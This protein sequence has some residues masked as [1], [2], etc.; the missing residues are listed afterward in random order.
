MA[1]FGVEWQ[2]MNLEQ[3]RTGLG[4][5][6]G[7]GEPPETVVPMAVRFAWWAAL[8]SCTTI[9]AGAIAVINY[10]RH[11]AGNPANA[12]VVGEVLL[13]LVPLVLWPVLWASYGFIIL[14]R[15]NRGSAGGR[16]LSLIRS[17]LAL[18]LIAIH[19]LMVS[20]AGIFLWPNLDL[21]M[22]SLFAYIVTEILFVV[23]SII[24]LRIK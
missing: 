15:L 4:P 13:V 1:G 2:P 14:R 20:W 19:I 24:R 18:P 5:G 8:V 12:N 3:Q 6:A 16:R 10:A 11:R 9:I 7:S 23:S 22:L 17:W 21:L